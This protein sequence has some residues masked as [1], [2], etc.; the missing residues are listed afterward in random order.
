[1]KLGPRAL[2]V[3]IGSL[4]AVA[5]PGLAFAGT[6]APAAGQP[7]TT[8]PPAAATPPASAAPAMP[9]PQPTPQPYAPPPPQPYA[10]APAAP[11][12]YPQAPQGYPQAAPPG[13]PPPGA[14]PAYYYPPPAYP[15]PGYYP[16]NRLALLDAEIS[17]LRLQHDSISLGVPIGFMIGGG[18][19]GV[20]GLALAD[21]P[22]EYDYDGNFGGCANEDSRVLGAF[23]A[24]GGGVFVTIGI[25][26]T[27]VRSARRGRLSRQI[28]LREQEAAA[29]RGAP[30]RFG[31]APTRGGGAMTLALDF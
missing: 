1:M 22:C 27:I 24:I 15:P 20:I 13:Y 2:N 26:Q 14:P 9:A 16:P 23:M 30:P 6:P 7:T 10:P 29:L 12:G 28:R 25:I 31:F 5:M 17:S 4:I 8:T 18:V 21:Q 11:Q 19:V 3:L